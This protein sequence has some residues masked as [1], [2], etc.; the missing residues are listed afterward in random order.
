MGVNVWEVVA[1]TIVQM[2]MGFFW[3]GPGF[4]KQWMKAMGYDK[5]SKK[6]LEK[7][8]QKGQKSMIFM[9]INSIITAAVLSCILSFFNPASIGMGAVFG[10]VVWL[11]F[12]ATS[13]M[14]SVLWDGKPWS[15]YIINTGFYLANMVIMGA[16]MAAIK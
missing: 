5:M 7:M 11:G 8:K 12:Y 15:L 1:G 14:G 9:V 6:D 4:G 3:Y 2:G 16:I 10:F 13:Q